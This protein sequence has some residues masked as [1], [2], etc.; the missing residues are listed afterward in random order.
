MK[1]TPL[2]EFIDIKEKFNRFTNGAHK[3]D[4]FRYYYLYIKGGVYIDS[5]AV[6]NTNIGEIYKNYVFSQSK[7]ITR[8][9][10]LYLMDLLQQKAK[11]KVIYEA[12]KDE[13]NISDSELNKD[14]HLICK[15]L[16]KITQS[17]PNKNIYPET[18]KQNFYPDIQTFDD[19]GNL[20]LTHYCKLKKVP[21]FKNN[22]LIKF[23]PYIF[24]NKILYKYYRGI[25]KFFSI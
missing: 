6:L 2:P 18:P 11:N 14:Y 25:Q 20:L 16:W 3:A 9:Y 15:N 4:L 10:L 17:L 12:L 7:V 8:T 21:A 22:W 13:Y 19:K 5:D 23:Y 1:E 24:K